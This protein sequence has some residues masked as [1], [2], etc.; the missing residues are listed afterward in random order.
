MQNSGLRTQEKRGLEEA[1]WAGL[2]WAGLCVHE[3]EK[4]IKYRC[5]SYR[6][7]PHRSGE[8]SGTEARQKTE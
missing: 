7:T 5:V 3:I 4:V 2:G 8:V 1:G 6:I